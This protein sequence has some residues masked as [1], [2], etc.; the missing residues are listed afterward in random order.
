MRWLPTLI[1]VRVMPH[2]S[3]NRSTKAVI[4]ANVFVLK[5]GG[6]A[7]KTGQGGW[8]PGETARNGVQ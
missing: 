7:H 5:F 3:F 2:G 8:D 4:E 1:S 6:V